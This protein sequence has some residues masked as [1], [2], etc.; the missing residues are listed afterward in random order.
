MLIRRKARSLRPT[1]KNISR[2]KVER[3]EDRT[4]LSAAFWSGYGGNAQHTANSPV[5]GQPMQGIVWQSSVD[6]N[7]QYS[8]NDLLIHYGEPAVTQANTL[9]IPVKTGATDGFRIEARDGYT[10]ALRW[11]L[12]T[13]YILPSHNW[14]PSFGPVM[15]PAGRVYFAGAGGT[16]YYFDNPD[17]ATAPVVHQLAFYGLPNYQANAAGFNSSV[18]ID[19]PLT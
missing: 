11:T 6:L 1:R 5:A 4:L 16:V 9:I 15:P 2:P 19:T 13:D 7:P 3:L 14:T 12:P 17:S 10:G 8:G 18:F